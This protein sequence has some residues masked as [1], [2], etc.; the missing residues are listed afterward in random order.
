M[1]SFH[2]E[3]LLI[4]SYPTIVSFSIYTFAHSHLHLIK[5]SSI[6]TPSHIQLNYFSLN[7]EW[8][9]TITGH[10]Y[11]RDLSNYLHST[12]SRNFALREWDVNFIAQGGAHIHHIQRLLPHITATRP[13]VVIIQ[14]GGNDFS[15]SATLDHI[16]VADKLRRLAIAIANTGVA[17][18]YICKLFY[19][20]QSRWLP[21]TQ[22]VSQYNKKVDH[23]NEALSTAKSDLQMSNIL[24][25]NHKG[26]QEFGKLFLGTDGT[27]LN[28]WGMK[29]IF[30]SFK[31]VLIHSRK[32][33]EQPLE[34]GTHG[35]LRYSNS[36]LTFS[37]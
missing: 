28:G 23:I 20:G 29:K 3:T 2:Y 21:S 26:Q 25:W 12:S 1:S 37:C 31:G 34:S 33:L 17:R 11:I 10:S 18:V 36:T 9:C 19:R 16:S 8:R 14:V 32:A 15:G 24:V 7:Q 35:Q 30:R 4:S 6:P 27:H 5:H 13:H 22:H